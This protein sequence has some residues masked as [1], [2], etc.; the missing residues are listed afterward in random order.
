[1]LLIETPS[2]YAPVFEVVKKSSDFLANTSYINIS[3]FQEE[4]D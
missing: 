2:K 4:F 1:M 3:D